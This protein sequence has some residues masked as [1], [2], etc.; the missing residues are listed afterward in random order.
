M[1]FSV[2]NSLQFKIKQLAV[3]TKTGDI[4]DISQMYEEISIFDSMF[5][6]VISGNI[7][8]TDSVGLSSKLFFDGSEALLIEIDKDEN[9]DI[10]SFKKSLRIYKQSER[11]NR[12]LNAE[13]YVLYFVSDELFYSDQQRINQSFQTTY[14]GVAEKILLNYLSVAENNL[15]GVFDVSYGI[16]DIKIPNM[17]PLE[18][19]EWCSKRAVDVNLAPNFMFFQNMNGFNFATL[20]NLLNK[21]DIMNIKFEAKNMDSSEKISEISSAR[22]LEVVAQTDIINKTRSGINASQFIGFDPTTRTIAKK[23]ISFGDVNATMK[24]A[25]ENPNFSSVKNRAGIDSQSM[26]QSKQTVSVFSAAQPL[27]K[28]VK[29]ND[30]TSLSKNEQYEVN[31]AQRKSII[32]NLMSKRVK[33]VMPGNFQLM[34]GFNVSL[35][36]PVLAM[37]EKGGENTDTSVSGKYIIVATRHLIKFDKHET[38]LEIAATSSDNEFIPV[39]SPEQMSVLTD[40]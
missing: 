25:N 26:F 22:A 37:K 28:Y 38:I 5:S 4:L 35:V 3:V 24:N 13:S 15:G 1:D 29:A 2:K 14:S 7:L 27:S 9:S 23:D 31:M 6:P 40:Y 8:I 20:S 21:E 36:A 30:P 33:L 39:S 18:A 17:R 32:A 11:K 16:R 34:S 10:A 19:I 12:G